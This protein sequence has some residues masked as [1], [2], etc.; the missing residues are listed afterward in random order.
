MTNAVKIAVQR[1]DGEMY[2]VII[3]LDDGHGIER[4]YSTAL[5]EAELRRAGL[6]GLPFRRIEDDEIPADRAFRNAWADT[7]A[8]VEVDMPKAVEIHKDTLRKVRAPLLQALD[9]E[10]MAA[11]AKGDTKA[12]QDIEAQKQALRDVT[13]DP[14][15]A[16]AKTPEELNAAIPEVLTASAEAE[17]VKAR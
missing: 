15:I 2:I 4:E 10:M 5:A 3:I 11:W 16:A 14:R 13:A 17:T 6:G 7:G 12:G 1:P 8:G 9:I